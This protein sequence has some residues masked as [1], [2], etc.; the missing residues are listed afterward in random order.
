M[1]FRLKI[2]CPL[3]CSSAHMARIRKCTCETF[4]SAAD[5]ADVSL[6]I[7]GD[8]SDYPKKG[9]VDIFARRVIDVWS[10]RE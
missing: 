7:W 4:D 3:L 8:Y 10:F 5:K 2:H 9:I 1:Q 6:L